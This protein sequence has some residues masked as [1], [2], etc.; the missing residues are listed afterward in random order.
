MYV[1]NVLHVLE[2]TLRHGVCAALSH[3]NYEISSQFS[4]V[5]SRPIRFAF[6]VIVVSLID[7][8]SLD[9]AFADIRTCTS[10]LELSAPPKFR[11]DTGNLS[12]Y[13]VRGKDVT[14]SEPHSY[15]L[16]GRPCR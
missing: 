13:V 16:L 15:D 11:C 14:L 9:V 4:Y 2:F 8:T 7:C 1:V 6:L 10:M 12:A 5:A 3:C